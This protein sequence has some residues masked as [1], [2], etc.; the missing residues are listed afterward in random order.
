MSRRGRSSPEYAIGTPV[1]LASCSICLGNLSYDFLLTHGRLF[2]LSVRMR[3]FF[4]SFCLSFF[5]ATAQESEPVILLFAGDVVLSDH[6]ENFIGDDLAYVF[7]QWAE[8]GPY[9]VFMV[10]LEHPVTTATQKVEKKFNFKMHPRLLPVLTGAGVTVVNLANNHIAD[11][12]REGLEETLRHLD[13]AGIRYVG[14]G[15]NLADARKPFIL[16]RNGLRIAFL[17]YYG[18]GE[19]A[20][21]GTRSGFAP[22]RASMVLEDVRAARQQADYVVVNFHWGVERAEHP[23]PE[24]VTLAHAVIDAGADLIVG[25]HP[26]VVQG[27]EA[28][29]GKHIAYSLGNFVFGGNALHTYDTVVLRVTLTAGN[30]QVEVIPVHVQ[31]WQP[32]PAVGARKERILRLVEER[33]KLFQ[34][35]TSSLK[36]SGE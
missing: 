34:S 36:G 21:T 17:A 5:I 28:Y 20:A 14:V 24:Q 23:E 22:R 11:Y 30:A 7:R 2:E 12:G 1:S 31:R 3:K 32:R 25:H 27:I 10:N 26:H 18:G 6:V 35:E 15:K 4:V 9:H 29:R 13:A 16:E 8:V 33:S 19:F